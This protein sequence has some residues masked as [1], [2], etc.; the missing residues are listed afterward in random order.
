MSNVELKALVF[1]VTG[2]ALL[3]VGLVG[4]GAMGLAM[5]NTSCDATSRVLAWVLWSPLLIGGPWLIIL[6][7]TTP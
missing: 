4:R 7:G 3:L 5:A 2:A 6:A 1:L